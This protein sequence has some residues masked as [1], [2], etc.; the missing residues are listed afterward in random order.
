[1][2]RATVPAGG[3]LDYSYEAAGVR[4]PL[5]RAIV[6]IQLQRLA[7][8]SGFKPTD[9]IRKLVLELD[10]RNLFEGFQV[11]KNEWGAGPDCPLLRAEAEAVARAP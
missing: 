2:T 4:L 7:L 6:Q 1:M 5:V 3:H 11:L 9:E 8:L 10:R